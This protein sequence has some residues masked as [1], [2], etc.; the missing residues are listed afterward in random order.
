MRTVHVMQSS[1][2]PGAS[3]RR[4]GVV[5]ATLLSW[6]VEYQLKD[7]TNDRL[8]ARIVNPA[9]F[10]DVT[11]D[12]YDCSDR[13]IGIIKYTFDWK[14]LFQ[15]RYKVHQVLDSAGNHVADMRQ[16]EVTTSKG[17]LGSWQRFIYLQDRAGNP[18]AA[19]RHPRG[20][21]K[22]GPFGEDLDVQI[23][24]LSMNML[25]PKPSMDPEFLSLVFA[26]SLASSS[27]F[28]PGC[29]FIVSCIFWVLVLSLICARCGARMK[30]SAD[31]TKEKILEEKEGLLATRVSS[32]PTTEEKVQQK[33]RDIWACCSRRGG[34]TENK[35][36]AK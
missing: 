29:G 36:V 26:N 6:T 12:I 22:F 8:M 18:L 32:E 15:N 4:L 14:D 9:A 24:L 3:D 33:G 10:W 25:A 7:G 2:T 35:V 31:R 20:G 27:R 11:Q 17:F 19:M 13:K 1:A 34:A 23:E 16:E 30:Q 21:W 5:S 28:G